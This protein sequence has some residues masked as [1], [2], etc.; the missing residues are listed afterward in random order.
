MGAVRAEHW[1]SMSIYI[2][3]MVITE[4]K[5]YSRIVE[6]YIK[7]DSFLKKN[8]TSSLTFMLLI[9]EKKYKLNASKRLVATLIQFRRQVNTVHNYVVN[10]YMQ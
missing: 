7:S 4:W 3:E 5:V 1:L 9:E 10:T 2:N 6:K 8:V